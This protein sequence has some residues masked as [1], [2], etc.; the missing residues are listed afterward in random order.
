MSAKYKK[1]CM[2]CSNYVTISRYKKY[3]VCDECNEKELNQ[4]IDDPKYKKLFDI[5]K[6]FY[7]QNS[8]LRDI[9]LNYLRYEKLSEKQVAA[10]K[11]T[12][13]EMKK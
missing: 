12:V 4:E 8:F 10:F 1:K 6:K 5:P 3:V 13:K 9:K 7:K 11:K 2:R